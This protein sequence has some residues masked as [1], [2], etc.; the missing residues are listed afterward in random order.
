MEISG[1]SDLIAALGGMAAR[2]E[3]ATPVAVETA[4]AVIE[5]EARAALSRYSHQPGTPTPAPPGGPPAIVTGRLRSSFM[6][7]GPTARGTGVWMSTMGP[8]MPYARI[9]ELGG[10]AGRNGSATLPARPYLKP[11]FE[12]AA[13]TGRLS[14][15][16]I[17]AW[18]AAVAG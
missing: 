15:V 10:Q 7:A 11:A 5:G 1:I 8:T 13:R 12:A 6:L 14:Q 2:I 18:G 4:Q 3:A 9:Q 16:F 17:R